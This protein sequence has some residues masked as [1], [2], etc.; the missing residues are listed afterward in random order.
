[1]QVRITGSAL[2]PDLFL[3]EAEGRLRPDASIMPGVILP[4][5]VPAARYAGESGQ[6]VTLP[7]KCVEG[8]LSIFE[9]FLTGLDSLLCRFLHPFF[10]FLQLSPYCRHALAGDN[11]GASVGAPGYRAWEFLLRAKILTAAAAFPLAIAHGLPVSSHRSPHMRGSPSSSNRA[12][13]ARRFCFT[14]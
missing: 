3:A 9:P 13:S 2:Q 4:L 11:E 10:F 12:T 1:G 7:D 14:D 8:G 6:C 5:V